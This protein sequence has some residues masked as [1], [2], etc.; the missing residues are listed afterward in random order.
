MKSLI[1][2]KKSRSSQSSPN[3]YPDFVNKYRTIKFETPQS[4]SLNGLNIWETIQ[5]FPN[6]K[7]H[8]R[9]W[10]KVYNLYTKNKISSSQWSAFDNLSEYY[11]RV[12]LTPDSSL[13]PS[14][15]IVET[16]PYR[17]PFGRF[18][19]FP[20]TVLKERES[21]YWNWLVYEADKTNWSET[22]KREVKMQRNEGSDSDS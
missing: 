17:I 6:L 22:M 1:H 8:M 19:D 15:R 11:H 7:D 12:I 16:T 18:K 2:P 9:L 20:L 3:R 13:E 4:K 10:N 21:N 5:L 14:P